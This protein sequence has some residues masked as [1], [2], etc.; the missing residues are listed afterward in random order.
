MFSI[1]SRFIRKARTRGVSQTPIESSQ[2]ITEGEIFY[3]KISLASLANQRKK[4]TGEW[5]TILDFK[6]LEIHNQKQV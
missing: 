6:S 4:K 2:T 1:M 5:G 3:R